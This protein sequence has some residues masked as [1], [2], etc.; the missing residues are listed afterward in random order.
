VHTWISL[1]GENRMDFMHEF[2]VDGMKQE[3]QVGGGGN[4]EIDT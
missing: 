1:V 4:S 3:H 2:G